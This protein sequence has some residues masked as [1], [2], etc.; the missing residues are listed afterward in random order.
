LNPLDQSISFQDFPQGV[1]FCQRL[2]WAVAP[3][4]LRLTAERIIARWSEQLLVRT[5]PLVAA[6]KPRQD[7]HGSRSLR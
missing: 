1:L 6:L 2:R 5:V 3:V 7:E 4:V